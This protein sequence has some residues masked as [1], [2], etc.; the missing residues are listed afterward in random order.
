MLRIF[1]TILKKIISGEKDIKIFLDD[2]TI[3]K[4]EK[5]YLMI[6]L[7]MENFQKVMF[8]FLINLIIT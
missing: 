6:N 5:L 2:G 7:K 3:L 1:F 8:I 4:T